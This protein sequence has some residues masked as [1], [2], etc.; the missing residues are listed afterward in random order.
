M[1]AS[2]SSQI[3]ISNSERKD[4]RR[5][6]LLSAGQQGLV[7]PIVIRERHRERIRQMHNVKKVIFNLLGLGL[8]GTPTHT[9]TVSTILTKKLPETPGKEIQ[10][11][12]VNY[13]PGAVDAIHRHNAHAVVTFWKEKLRCKFAEVRFSGSARDRSFTNRLKTFTPCAVM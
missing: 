9:Q 4:G 5:G 6:V 3:P 11:V 1:A 10:V 12:T 7:N 13:A 2:P 8:I